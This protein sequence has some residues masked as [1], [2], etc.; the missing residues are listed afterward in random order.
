MNKQDF[1]KL[2]DTLPRFPGVYRFIGHENEILY[3]G[4]AKN[5]K[6]R[7]SNYFTGGKSRTYK[8]RA[9]VKNAARV[10]YTVVETEHDA[11]LLENNLIKEHQPRYN[12]DLRDD[13]TYTY[14][15]VK[16]ERFP[17]VFFTRKL[18][19]DGSTY[20]GPYTSKYKARVVLDLI[21]KLF[22]L[23][24]CTFNLSENNITKGKFKICLEYH[25][26][27]C[28]GPCEG[29]ETE[30]EYNAKIE[31]VKDM[32]K[33]RLSYV[34]RQIKEDM[35][36]ASE[37]LN[38]EKAQ[39]LKVKLDA[40]EDYHS[41]S[42]VVSQS[43]EDLDVFAIFD[44]DKYAYVSYLKIVEG[45]IVHAYSAELIKN[46]DDSIPDLLSHAVFR[47]RDKFGSVANHL[48]LPFEID[49]SEHDMQ[50][51]I[52]QR[53]SRH[54]LLE[55]AKQ[56]AFFYAQQRERQRKEK[57][58]RQTPAERI[59]TTLKNDLTMDVMPLHI[60]CFDNS[61]LGGSNPVASCVVFKNGKPSKKDYRKF[62]IKTVVGPD[63]FASMTEIVYRRYKRL[64]DE[65]QELPQ[66]VIIDGG[67]G[68]LSASMK[69]IEALDLQDKIVVIG[70]AKR[71][72]EI[73]FPGD[74]I[75]LY[76]NKKSESLKLIQQLRN[77]AHRFAI[78]FH[79]DKRSQK[80]TKSSL[81]DIPGVGQVTS[82][83][84]LKHFKSIKRMKAATQEELK[85]V[86]GSKLADTLMQY[87]D[88]GEPEQPMAE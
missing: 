75:P 77:E 20:Y 42:A 38:F 46:L 34:K 32:L 62:N 4:K 64:L 66:L 31:Q 18:I 81:I 43:E 40:V 65:E 22:P 70:I 51:T 53:G 5:L 76:I 41:Q 86:V 87:L 45:S 7:V 26:G 58:N 23:R 14:I 21:K 82:Q 29:L 88:K 3:V 61:N 63:D 11:L 69:S 2:S 73:F 30:V 12:V 33:G 16:N 80:F 8:T 49:Y 84:L 55:L 59:L 35:A 50:V 9:L 13:K 1:I 85:E 28:M 71:L 54:Q 25:L 15:C 6:N 67:K 74:S 52:P 19:R 79:R 72:E 17:R 56:N 36:Q 47:I 27:N 68:Q 60:E 24:T 78:T 83:K 10:E 48:V 44:R 37:E 39:R 57:T